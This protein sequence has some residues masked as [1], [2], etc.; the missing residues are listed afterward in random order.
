[1]LTDGLE[2]CGL[3]VDYCDV[4]ISCLYSHSFWRY[5]FTAEDPLVSKWYNAK[6]LQIC[7]DEETNS[8]T[9][10]MAWGWVNVELNFIFGWTIP[11]TKV[12][13]WNLIVKCYHDF[14]VTIFDVTLLLFHFVASKDGGFLHMSTST[15]VFAG[16]FVVSV[17]VLVGILVYNSRRARPIDRMHLLSTFWDPLVTGLRRRT[18]NYILSDYEL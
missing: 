5:P 12:H 16:L 13:E 14:Y 3:L 8:S 9:L 4:F 11:L 7:F 17:V 2:W 1:M 10:W 6:F 15:G 18:M